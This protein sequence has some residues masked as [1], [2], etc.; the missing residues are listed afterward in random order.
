MKSEE[1]VRACGVAMKI[2][3]QKRSLRIKNLSAELADY[4]ANPVPGKE[5][6]IETLQSSIQTAQELQAREA[7]QFAVIRWVLGIT[8]EI[9]P[10]NLE[11]DK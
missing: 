4:L 6:K 1:Q 10:T 2:A 9:D 8:P 7:Y 5:A 3:M 11:L